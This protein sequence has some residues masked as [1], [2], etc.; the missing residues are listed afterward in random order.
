MNSKLSI[1]RLSST[2]LIVAVVIGGMLYLSRGF[3]RGPLFDFIIS[4]I[5]INQIDS[6]YRDA[7]GTTDKLNKRIPRL[8]NKHL[9]DC[10][11]MGFRGLYIEAKCGVENTVKVDIDQ[12]DKS[13]IATIATELEQ[14][15]WELTKLQIESRVDVSLTKYYGKTYCRVAI[16]Q[17]SVNQI[18]FFTACQR[19]VVFF[20]GI[21]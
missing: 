4:K 3:L 8:R 2:S 17:G 9:S 14:Q 16:F 10:G 20:G 13:E 21:Y 1:K 18:F 15:N 19:D 11:V 7:F 12:I 6:S 5:Y